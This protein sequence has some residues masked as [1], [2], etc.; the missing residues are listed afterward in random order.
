[1]TIFPPE[2]VVLDMAGTTID[3]GQQVYRVLAET[4][5]AHGASPSEADIARWHG[6]SKHEA[7]REL[8]TS[9][10]GTPPSVGELEV[11]VADFHARLSTAYAADHPPHP[12]PGV[13]E[14][15]S[16]LRERGVKVALTTG[17]DRVIVESLLS[18]LGWM[19]DAV[20]DTVVCGSDVA[21][22]RPA[23]YMIFRAM[24]RLGVT[25]VARVLV[26]GDTPRDLE[27]GTNSGAAMVVGV[28]SGASDADELGAHRHTHLL[29]SVA[30]LPG[31]LGVRPVAVSAP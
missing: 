7:L 29:P 10:S 14:A 23:P 17:F 8:L 1:M 26:A 11:V 16:T 20:A 15:L 2:V 27:A 25:D 13:V 21:A 31:L 19:G 24:E 22:G 3:D 12:L 28:L 6:A 30:D 18:A 4:A 9:R 5:S